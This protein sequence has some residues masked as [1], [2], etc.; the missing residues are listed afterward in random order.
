VVSFRTEGDRMWT[1]IVGLSVMLFGVVGITYADDRLYP[2]SIGS[3]WGVLALFVGLAYL[4]VAEVSTRT[5]VH[6]TS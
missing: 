5:G 4:V 3:L 6:D 1:W 2:S